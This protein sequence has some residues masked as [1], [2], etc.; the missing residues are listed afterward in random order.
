MPHND[1]SLHV[2][3]SC[4]QEAPPRSRFLLGDCCT[5]AQV[6]FQLLGSRTHTH[7]RNSPHAE[8]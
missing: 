2:S 5:D 6:P 7:T 4:P 8:T 3:V 1:W